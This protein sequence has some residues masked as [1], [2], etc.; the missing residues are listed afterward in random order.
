MGLAFDLLSSMSLLSLTAQ[1]GSCFSSS[2][3]SESDM[4]EIRLKDYLLVDGK[5]DAGMLKV[6]IVRKWHMLGNLISGQC[7]LQGKVTTFFDLRHRST[8]A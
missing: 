6:R 2:F 4:I 3:C 7:A 1:A 8:S 5:F